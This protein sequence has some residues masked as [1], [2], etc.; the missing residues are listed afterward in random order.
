MPVAQQ[1]EG[2]LA[3]AK[4]RGGLERLVVDGFADF[5]AQCL[6]SFV[7]GL[8]CSKATHTLA[9]APNLRNALRD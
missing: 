6:H 8:G 4:V 1:S 7:N 5:S 9:V 2:G 3:V